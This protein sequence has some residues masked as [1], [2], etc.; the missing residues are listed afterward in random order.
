MDGFGWII[1]LLFFGGMLHKLINGILRK[2]D[3]V[4][5][6]HVVFGNSE[7]REDWLGQHCQNQLHD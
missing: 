4:R 7:Q 6:I 3:S 1:I 5:E 2:L